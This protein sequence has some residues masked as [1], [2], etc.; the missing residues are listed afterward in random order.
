MEANLLG[1]LLLVAVVLP[2]AQAERAPAPR[3]EKDLLGEKEV[4]GDAY[5]GVLLTLAL[6]KPRTP[7]QLQQLSYTY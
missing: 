7:A 3:V 2:A 1:G 5:Y 6:L 4:P